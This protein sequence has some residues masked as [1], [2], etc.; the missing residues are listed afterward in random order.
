MIFIKKKFIFEFK[1]KIMK[2]FF[3]ILKC[4]KIKMMIIIK[5]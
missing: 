1:F 5:I 3:N 4:L 2:I